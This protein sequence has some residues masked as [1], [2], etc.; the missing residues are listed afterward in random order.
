MKKQITTAI[1]I[2]ILAG[3]WNTGCNEDNNTSATTM[4]TSQFAGAQGSCTNGGVK[5]EVLVDGVVDEAQTQYICNGAQGAQGQAG[6]QGQGGSN[7][8]M[9][10]TPFTGNEGGCTNGG[11]K[12]E[13]LVDGVVD[14]AQTQYIC[15]GAQGQGGQSGT[16]TT[17]KTTKFEGAEGGCTNGGVKIEV[18]V[19]G[20]VDNAQTQY[21]CNGAQGGQG[22]GGQNMSMRTT[23]F[24]GA[25]GSCKN[26]GVKIEVLVDGVV[27]NTQTQYICNGEQGETGCSNGQ[28][29]CDGA[30][31]DITANTMHCG[32]CGHN[33]NSSKPSHASTMTCAE[34]QCAIAACEDG[35]IPKDGQCVSCSDVAGWSKCNGKCVQTDFDNQ[36]CG[37]CGKT[38]AGGLT[39]GNGK[40]VGNTTCSGLTADTSSSIDNCGA[41]GN[42]CPDGKTCIQGKCVTGYGKAYCGAEIV[43]IGDIERCGG[44][45]DKCG[46][47][48]ICKNNACVNGAGPSYCDG[49]VTNTLNSISNCGSCGHR[50]EDN[51]ICT[52]GECVDGQGGYST[53]EMYCNGAI[54]HYLSDSANCNGCG[55]H[56][57][58][59]LQCVAGTCQPYALNSIASLTCNGITVNPYNDSYNCG[60]CGTNCGTE[61][62]LHGSC[63]GLANSNIITFGHYEQDND[64]SNGKEPIEWRVL[65]VTNS[66]YLIIS[67]KVLDV[68]PYNT[69]ST[70]ITWEK[71]TIRSWLN[72]YDASY[73]TVGNDYTSDNFI[74]TAF[75]AEEKA[76]ILSSGVSAHANPK[77]STNP[78]NATQDKIFLLSVVEANN[79]YTNDADRQADATRYAVGTCTDVHC[80]ASWWLRSPG[81]STNRAADVYADGSVNSSGYS[82]FDDGSGVRP[83][84][85][86]QY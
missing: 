51:S 83:A 57:A 13:V 50:C 28:K 22:Q 27:D 35:Y 53:D 26:G 3:V 34:S 10:T 36:N 84:L 58:K 33:C 16:N 71:S 77:Y 39:C 2:A 55:N 9:R 17:I 72:G 23:P 41:C 8:T 19:D 49:R 25:Q 69:T 24:E 38:C 48:K 63:G 12:F 60:K 6:A 30:C 37:S 5:I 76:R 81:S 85:W 70:S 40:C 64:T 86:V 56:C 21:I 15:N 80:Y 73:N 4:R 68:K 42:R 59:G 65:E 78:G 75:T 82:V 46:N 20:V 11:I 47:G 14:D 1:A 7:T 43:Q 74:D 67:E 61:A 18:L 44:C 45:N 31:T 62:C 32:A 66:S 52:N 29:Y 79:Y 54:I